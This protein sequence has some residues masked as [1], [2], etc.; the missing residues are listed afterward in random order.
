VQRLCEVFF[1]CGPQELGVQRA[2]VRDH[3]LAAHNRPL[4]RRRSR[5]TIVWNLP[6]FVVVKAPLSRAL[7]ASV[8][9]TASRA[10]RAMIASCSIYGPAS[11]ANDRHAMLPAAGA[12]LRSPS[13]PV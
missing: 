3:R 13:A 5:A 7:D 9:P 8:R 10:A 4:S 11:R 1:L 2:A 12:L 6:G